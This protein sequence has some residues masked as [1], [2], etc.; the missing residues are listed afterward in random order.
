MCIFLSSLVCS[1]YH[2][3]GVSMVLH[4]VGVLDHY[5]QHG[6]F[7]SGGEINLHR[8]KFLNFFL[9]NKQ[10]F[11]KEDREKHK[12]CPTRE[13]QNMLKMHPFQQSAF[14]LQFVSHSGC[15][16]KA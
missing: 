7:F 16:K 14:E 5:S 4:N 8:L 6:R 2:W 12:K 11:I 9:I 10:R 3:L 1:A 13:V 15:K